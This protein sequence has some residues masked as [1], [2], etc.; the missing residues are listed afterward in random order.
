MRQSLRYDKLQ[1]EF[2]LLQ[3]L[4][5]QLDDTEAQLAVLPPVKK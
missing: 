2:G 4:G 3:R 1:Q 5:M